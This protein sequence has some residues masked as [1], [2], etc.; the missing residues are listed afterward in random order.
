MRGLAGKPWLNLQTNWT[1]WLML[2]MK[3]MVK[4]SPE[5]DFM[6]TLG[7]TASVPLKDATAKISDGSAAHCQKNWCQQPKEP[8]NCCSGSRCC[9]HL[10]PKPASAAI[11][12][13]ALCLPNFGSNLPS[14]DGRR[15]WRCFKVTDFTTSL[16]NLAVRCFPT[17][18]AIGQHPDHLDRS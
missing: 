10:L 14:L 18:S 4:A 17:G 11:W 7:E 8:Q 13:S 6:T 1:N 3:L 2:L 15:N 12:C 5:T 9:D 16:L